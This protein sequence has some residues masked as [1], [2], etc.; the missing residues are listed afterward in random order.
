V[1]PLEEKIL[2][3]GLS[4]QKQLLTARHNHL[5]GSIQS[6]FPDGIGIGGTPG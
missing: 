1:S 2:Q 3:K 6:V 4:R 5:T